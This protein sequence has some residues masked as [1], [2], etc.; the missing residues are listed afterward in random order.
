MSE[1][2]C[3]PSLAAKGPVCLFGDGVLGLVTVNGIQLS[4][5]GRN[6]TMDLSEIDDWGLDYDGA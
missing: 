4:E 1:A 6:E 2:I 5:A 3:K